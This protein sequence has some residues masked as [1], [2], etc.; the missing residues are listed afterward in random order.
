MNL[1]LRLHAL[2][3]NVIIFGYEMDQQPRLL[4]DATQPPQI[5]QEND[6]D[7]DDFIPFNIEEINL[8]K[9]VKRI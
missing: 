9:F 8:K 5:H 1:I 3:I 4:D 2:R 6:Q 7:D